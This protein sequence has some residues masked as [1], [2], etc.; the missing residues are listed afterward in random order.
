MDGAVAVDS[1]VHRHSVPWASAPVAQRAPWLLADDRLAQDTWQA[2]A[3]GTGSRQGP[4]AYTPNYAVDDLLKAI[5]DTPPDLRAVANLL[6][7]VHAKHLT[8][9]D[10]SCRSENL[11]QIAQTLLTQA[12]LTYGKPSET[13]VSEMRLRL[14]TRALRAFNPQDGGVV[15]WG[16][17]R[18]LWAAM[19]KR[20]RI[21]RRR[22]GR[23]AAAEFKLH[24]AASILASFPNTQTRLDRAGRKV[25]DMVLL[26]AAIASTFLPFLALGAA[27]NAVGNTAASFGNAS[28]ATGM[29]CLD[30]AADLF[31]RKPRPAPWHHV[32]LRLRNHFEIYKQARKQQRED[33]DEQEEKFARELASYHPN[34][35]FL[36]RSWGFEFGHHRRI[37]MLGVLDLTDRFI[38]RAHSLEHVS[39]LLPTVNKMLN[40]TQ[41]TWHE[42]AIE[43]LLTLE[44]EM[45][46]L[47]GIQPAIVHT[48]DFQR[49]AE[50]LTCVRGH[51]GF[52]DARARWLSR[53]Q[54]GDI[55]AHEGH[56][57]GMH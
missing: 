40:S 20:K 47:R 21:F 28:G 8:P 18:D 5:C 55:L 56:N 50:L 38:R 30:V 49:A 52:D 27:R 6:A 37:F 54:M 7:F 48:H 53:A 43:V 4:F 44:S 32:Y 16:A 51:S 39:W 15:V 24:E 9:T 11:L 17:V 31:S 45:P 46:R 34:R 2:P 13:A 12:P 29:V 36:W 1:L 33:A 19:N 26:A 23:N 41:P 35:K 25:M 42:R 57:G 10:L 14:V 3:A 22:F